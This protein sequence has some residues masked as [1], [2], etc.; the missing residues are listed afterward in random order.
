MNSQPLTICAASQ[1]H[2]EGWRDLWDQYCGGAVAQEISDE[3]WR[4]ILDPS[5]PIGSV[6]ALAE[7]RVVGF[8]TY[9]EHECTWETKS[10][11]YVEDVFVSKL[12]R[13]PA[14]GVGHAM[15]GYLMNRLQAGKW[16]RVYGITHVENILAQRLYGRYTQGEPYLRYVVKANP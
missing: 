15:A 5:N 11:C 2:A 9:V 10:V 16:A 3:T 1:D 13:G 8:V 4:R 14:L 6:V 7:S 12:H